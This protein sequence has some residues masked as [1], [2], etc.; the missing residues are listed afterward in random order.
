MGTGAQLDGIA[1]QEV[2][3]GY[4]AVVMPIWHC[5]LRATAGPKNKNGC[6]CGQPL[7]CV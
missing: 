5:S 7:L 6:H 1:L 2:R 3:G 4:G